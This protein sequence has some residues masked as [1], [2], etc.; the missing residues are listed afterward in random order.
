MSTGA[1]FF[2][3]VALAFY[4]LTEQ[5]SDKSEMF[6]LRCWS[7]WWKRQLLGLC[8]WLQWVQSSFCSCGLAVIQECGCGKPL[9]NCYTSNSTLKSFQARVH[10]YTHKYIA[11]GL[12]EPRFH[13]MY[14]WALPLP[15]KQRGQWRADLGAQAFHG[16]FPFKT[17]DYSINVCNTHFPLCWPL[18][19]NEDQRQLCLL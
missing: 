1:F 4:L 12:E 10:T 7:G 3:N 18:E 5:M 15:I 16:F 8:W 2:C 14:L 11:S 19:R 17:K 6:E 9:K 13:L